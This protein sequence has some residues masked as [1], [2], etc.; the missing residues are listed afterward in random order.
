MLVTVIVRSGAKVYA[1]QHHCDDWDQLVPTLLTSPPFREFCRSELAIPTARPLS[2]DE[3]FMFVP[4]EPLAE[5]WLAQ[6]GREGKYFE[7]ICI[8]T[9]EGDNAHDNP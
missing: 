6:G 5:T 3:V 2:A 8:R 7:A 1:D 4:M 9:A